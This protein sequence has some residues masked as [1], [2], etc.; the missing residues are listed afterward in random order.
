MIIRLSFGYAVVK[1]CA[2]YDVVR[3][4]GCARDSLARQTKLQRSGPGEKLA[5]TV[6]PTACAASLHH[7]PTHLGSGAKVLESLLKHVEVY[8]KPSEHFTSP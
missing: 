7:P 4:S 3:S 5:L 2:D 6:H 1:R 8:E